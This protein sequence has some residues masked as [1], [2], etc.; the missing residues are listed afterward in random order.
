MNVI[1]NAVECHV[2]RLPTLSEGHIKATD[3]IIRGLGVEEGTTPAAR[4]I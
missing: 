3:Q 1:G 2:F 4:G